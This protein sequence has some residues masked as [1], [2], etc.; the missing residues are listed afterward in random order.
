VLRQLR[1]EWR[2]AVV[3]ALRWRRVMLFSELTNCT[4]H[5]RHRVHYPKV[6]RVRADGWRDRVSVKLLYGQCADTYATRA[7]ELAH[8]F[9]ARACRVRVHQPRRIWLD[10]VHADPLAQPVGVPALADPEAGVD[11]T[12]AGRY[13]PSTFVT[14]TLDSYGRVDGQGAAVDPDRYDYRRAARD[15]IHFSAPAVRQ[16]P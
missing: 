4:G 1:S 15:A 11:L 2:R 14:L 9:G 12:R 13:R 7:D 6:R 3:Y 8:S 5:G 10:L 16:R